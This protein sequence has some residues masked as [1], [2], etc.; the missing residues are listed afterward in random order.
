[1]GTSPTTRQNVPTG[2]LRQPTTRLTHLDHSSPRVSGYILLN[3]TTH[4]THLAQSLPRASCY[5]PWP[6]VA[7]EAAQ[8][9]TPLWSN[10]I[11]GA[12]HA[13][14]RTAAQQNEGGE[15]RTLHCRCHTCAGPHCS[16]GEGRGGGEDTA[17]RVPHSRRAA[18]QHRRRRGGGGGCTPACTS[19]SL[20]P[21]SAPFQSAHTATAC[22]P[23]ATSCYGL[24]STTDVHPV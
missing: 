9:S 13:Q 8:V 19:P 7:T 18:Q 6:W 5:S 11:V 17:L 16:T 24:P 10:T 15:A 2:C 3:H 22:C 23:P 21:P 12:T 14:G 20:N 1:M 4:P